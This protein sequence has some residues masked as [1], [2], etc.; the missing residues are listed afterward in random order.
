MPNGER[1]GLAALAKLNATNPD[2]SSVFTP[3]EQYNLLVEWGYGDLLKYDNSGP[4]LRQWK[5]N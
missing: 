3:R 4:G 2:N 5:T 1:G